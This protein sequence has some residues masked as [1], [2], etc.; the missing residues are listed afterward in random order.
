MFRCRR[1]IIIPAIVLATGLLGA[2]ARDVLAQPLA[3]PFATIS[4]PYPDGSWFDFG[5][6]GL[7]PLPADFFGPGSD[8]FEG[9]VAFEGEPFDTPGFGDASS[10]VLRSDQPLPPD[11]PPMSTGAVDIEI[12]ELS[13][14]S[15]EP[16]Q[17]TYNGG[18]NPEPWDVRVSLSPLVPSPGQ[19]V[20]FKT[21]DNG[22]TFESVFFVQPLFVFT[23]PTD[24]LELVLDTGSM[25]PP[26]ALESTPTE[27]WV[28]TVDPDL[29]VL[30]PSDGWFV[31]GVEELAGSPPIQLRDEIVFAEPTGAARY[32]V[33]PARIPS[34]PD[35]FATISGQ[36]PDGSFVHFGMGA[37]P[38]LPADYFGPGSDPFEGHV[39]LDGAPLDPPLW[40]DGSTL[41]QR[42]GPPIARSEPPSATGDVPI[43]IIALDLVSSEPI[44]VTYSGVPE[45]E[46]W[47]VRIT[48]S[49]ATPPAGTLLATKTHENGGTFH[50]TFF[51]QPTFTFTRVSDGEVRVLDTADAGMPALEFSIVGAP[52][53]HDSDPALGILAPSDGWFVPGVEEVVPSDPLSQELR[54]MIAD[55]V[56]GAARH[57]VFP[58]QPDPTSVVEIGAAGLAV[59]SYPNPFRPRTRIEFTLP[60]G[61]PVEIGVYDLS[62]RLVKRLVVADYGPGTH[63]VPWNGTD[64]RG[65]PVASGV[66][67]YRVTAAGTTVTDKVLRLR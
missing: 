45:P 41:T 67:F 23:R 66:Y 27:P 51:V 48:P 30:A 55:E 64:A 52:W 61:G 7:P 20:A 8:P 40:G 47:E 25:M 34:P 11:A 56:T 21:H 50:S 58:A 18:M 22:G 54:R 4:A 16:I 35:P 28:H 1:S 59:R 37:V 15:V 31:P 29:G 65:E 17:V 26:L 9:H 46:L 62:G 24:G 14:R 33:C 39:S 44:G 36:E 42:S 63:A 57:T 38:P 6:G 19:L 49:A 10:L 5:G 12:V 60:Q 32:T 3:D 43:E 2:G 53:V 13:L